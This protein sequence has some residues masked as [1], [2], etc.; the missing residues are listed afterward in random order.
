MRCSR[1]DFALEVVVDNQV[2]SIQ[3]SEIKDC[4]SLICFCY[5]YITYV[6]IYLYM[7]V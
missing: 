6:N 7:Y 4:N 5:S 3:A 1:H 2:A